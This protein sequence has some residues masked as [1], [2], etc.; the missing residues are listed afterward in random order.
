M[1]EVIF[2]M[3]PWHLLQRA[4]AFIA[5]FSGPLPMSS[6]V[7]S[8]MSSSFNKAPGASSKTYRR[9]LVRM[10]LLHEGYLY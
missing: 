1:Q 4:K 7:T 9:R 2:Q 8:A 10:V 3:P 6:M 5:E